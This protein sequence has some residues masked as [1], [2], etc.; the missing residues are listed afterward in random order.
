MGCSARYEKVVID[1][2]VDSQ[3]TILLDEGLHRSTPPMNQHGMLTRKLIGFI[4]PRQAFKPR[5]FRYQSSKAEPFRAANIVDN[6]DLLDAIPLEDIRTFSFI[7]HVD[8][9]KSSLSSRVLELA[10]NLG[11]E[12][13]LL[14]WN[15]ATRSEQ[16]DLGVVGRNT[17]HQDIN[18][19]KEQIELLDRLA[20]ERERGITVKA[21]TASM[22]YP[23]QSAVGPEKLLLINMVD[24]P[25]HVDFGR[26]VSRSLSFVQG[27]V[28]LLDAAQGIQAQT[29][30]VYE[31]VKALPNPPELLLAL[32]KVDLQSAKPIDVSLSVA[33]WLEWEDPD[34]IVLTSARDRIGVKEIL[35]AV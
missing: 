30:S 34:D 1:S 4:R 24:T 3:P 7:A 35:D 13:Q 18:S 5:A 11:R 32:T 26:E 6:T 12:A 21:S 8:H 25:G 22:L 29:W 2:V 31:K 15:A 33:E 14:A 9:G 23:H 10:G 20:V 19:G 16:P 27:A 28:L 17:D